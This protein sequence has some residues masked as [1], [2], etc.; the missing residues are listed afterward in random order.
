MQVQVKPTFFQSFD[1]INF[2]ESD[3]DKLGF[4]KLITSCLGPRS[5]T[6]VYNYSDIIKTIFYIHAIEGDILDDV[7]T[8]REQIKDHPDIALCSADTIEPA[9]RPA[10]M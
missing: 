6:A 2:M 4:K 7:N 5:L 3:Y 1:G 9:C 8:L 10:G